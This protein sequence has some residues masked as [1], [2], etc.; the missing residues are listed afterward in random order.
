MKC[1]IENTK[2]RK[3]VEGKNRKKSKGNKQK[4]V[5]NAGDINSTVSIITIE[6]NY[7]N[8]HNQK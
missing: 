5:T 4:T 2:C 6:S 7:I 1:S 3:R 8:N